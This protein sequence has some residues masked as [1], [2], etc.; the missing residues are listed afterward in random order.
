MPVQNAAFQS[1]SKPH[2]K[3][4]EYLGLV[5]ICE[6]TYKS[7]SMTCLWKYRE[8][9]KIQLQPDRDLRVRILV[10]STNP[11]PLD[12]GKH[13]V[14]ILQEGGWASRPV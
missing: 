1:L 3:L 6:D 4:M 8:G 14:P 2:G 5:A 7:H 13:P 9:V 10:V 11:Q 12:T